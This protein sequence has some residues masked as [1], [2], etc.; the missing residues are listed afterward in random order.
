MKKNAKPVVDVKPA[1][2]SVLIER[3][4]PQEALGTKLTLGDKSD[5]GA[6]QAYILAFG[7]NLPKECEL[8]VGDRVILQGSYVPMPNYDGHYRERG[9][10]E[11]HNI[12]AILVEE[13]NNE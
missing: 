7:P 9:V 11:I 4:N 8:K 3:L 1:N 5:Y 12:K 6:P 13:E 10:V 2:S